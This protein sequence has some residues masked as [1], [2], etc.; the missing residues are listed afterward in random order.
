[1]NIVEL[2]KLCGSKI[3]LPANFD[4]SAAAYGNLPGDQ[5]ARLSICMA[6]YILANRS[7]FNSAQIAASESVK[8]QQA[9]GNIY[10]DSYTFAEQLSDFANEYVKTVGDAGNAVLTGVSEAT[11]LKT[12]VT[13][14]AVVAVL[15]F[16]A[17][18]VLPK[19]KAAFAK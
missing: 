11:G 7:A 3:G 13:V 14:A 12:A 4:G 19:L 8:R 17:P 10:P 18:Y 15:Y 16:G 1:M 2:R 6:D 5:Q 9:S